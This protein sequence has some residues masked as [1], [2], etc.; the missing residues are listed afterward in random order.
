L[1]A[2]NTE[3][4]SS[5]FCRHPEPSFRIQQA[6]LRSASRASRSALR[7]LRS[8]RMHGVNLAPMWIRSALCQTHTHIHTYTLQIEDSYHSED[9]PIFTPGE[10]THEDRYICEVKPSEDREKVL[11]RTKCPWS[12]SQMLPLGP[13]SECDTST[14]RQR[15]AYMLVVSLHYIT[16]H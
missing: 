3:Q 1:V 9:H 10:S 11:G 2:S 7:M 4:S 14:H 16:L 15:Q 6:D 12:F 8:S 13:R 5:L